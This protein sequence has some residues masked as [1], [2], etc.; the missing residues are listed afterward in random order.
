MTKRTLEDVFNNDPLGLLDVKPKQSGR[1]S[2]ESIY[3]AMYDEVRAF[4]ETNGREPSSASK[5]I[6]E[7]QLGTR[8]KKI[9]NTQSALEILAPYDAKAQI[10]MPVNKTQ[11]TDESGSPKSIDDILSSDL[12]QDKIDIYNVSEVVRKGKTQSTNEYQAT[13]KKCDDFEHFNPCLSMFRQS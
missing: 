10:L 4:I 11:K 3:V 8:L 12:L 13:R 5:N 1:Q 2:N 6:N 9:R 7:A